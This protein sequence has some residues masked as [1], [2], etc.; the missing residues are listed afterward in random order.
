MSFLSVKSKTF[1]RTGWRV[2]HPLY[3]TAE[4]AYLKLQDES[5]L[6]VGMTNGDVRVWDLST[7][8]LISQTTL[9]PHMLSVSG[10]QQL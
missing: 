6:I 1:K 5:V 7:E 4:A 2:L 10:E 3:L 8:D 9:H